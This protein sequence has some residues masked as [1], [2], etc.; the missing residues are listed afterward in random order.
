MNYSAIWRQANDNPENFG[1]LALALFEFVATEN[2]VYQEFLK[3]IKSS[4]P[5]HWS[6]IPCLPVEVFKSQRVVSFMEEP[7]RIF[8]SSG[9][10]NNLV[11]KVYIKS[12]EDYLQKTISCFEKNYGK[13]TEYCFLALLPSYVENPNSSLIC[14][15]NHFI[16]LSECVDSAYYLHNF[17]VLTQKLIELKSKN[18]KTILFGV[19]YALLDLAERFSVDLSGIIVMETGGMKGRRKEITKEELHR[20]LKKSFGI[21]K[22]HSEYGMSELMSQFYSDGDGIFRCAPWMKVIA[23]D[24]H[25]PKEI[26]GPGKSGLL[27]I[28]DL[29]SQDNCPF[30][31]TQD[32]GKVFEDGSFEVIGRMDGSDMRGCNLLV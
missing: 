6:E 3:N 4:K 29:S 24:I 32:I 8:H 21:P 13:L 22:V 1:D 16:Q 27:S 23:H 25:D 11:S 2:V 18:Q 12:T 26:L 19:S 31:K 5:L 15:T 17:E 14:M 20:I 30:I 10:G 9:T 7:E 28:F